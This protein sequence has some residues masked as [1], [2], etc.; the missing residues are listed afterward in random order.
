[1][2]YKFEFSFNGVN[3]TSSTV[4][5]TGSLGFCY[6]FLYSAVLNT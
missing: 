1:M 4:C 3:I 5:Y 6:L 2:I